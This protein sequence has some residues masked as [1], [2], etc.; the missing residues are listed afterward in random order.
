MS[1][2]NRQDHSTSSSQPI[3]SAPKRSPFKWAVLGVGGVIAVAHLGILGHIMKANQD[4]ML[5][6]ASLPQYPNLNIPTGVYTSYDVNVNRDG[7][8]IRYNANDPKVL[9]QTRTTD[10]TKS[11][12]DKGWFGKTSSKYEDR[13]E[14]TVREYTMEG[15]R[16]YSGG[17]GVD[18]EGKLTAE[19]IAC[20]KAA[21]AGES[22]GGMIGA[23]MTSG[24]APALANIPYVGWLAS[25]WAVMLGQN[26]GSDLGAE[27]AETLNDC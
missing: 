19:K 18:P 3:P 15:Q 11:S 7:Y 14:T 5:R 25:G 20:I 22:T 13:D 23:S 26:I 10:L 9:R 17:E 1:L 27:V 12:D 6:M 16:G 4:A 8:N 2:I 21:G 24:V